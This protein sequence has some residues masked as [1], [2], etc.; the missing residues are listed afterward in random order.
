MRRA[1]IVRLLEN[2]ADLARDGA[3]PVGGRDGVGRQDG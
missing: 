1:P 2:A 3:L